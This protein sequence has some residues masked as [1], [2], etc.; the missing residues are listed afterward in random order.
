MG[1]VSSGGIIKNLQVIDTISEPSGKI[2]NNNGHKFL[3]DG[4][5]KGVDDTNVETFSRSKTA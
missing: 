5:I 1:I 3:W 4:L 2:E